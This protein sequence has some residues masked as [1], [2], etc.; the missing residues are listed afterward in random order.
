[1]LRV[2]AKLN[3][4]STDSTGSNFSTSRMSI[5]QFKPSPGKDLQGVSESGFLMYFRFWTSEVRVFILANYLL[6]WG[7]AHP[8]HACGH[9]CPLLIVPR[10]P[11]CLH[12]Q[13]VLFPLHHVHLSVLNVRNRDER[14][15][16]ESAL[17]KV[18]DKTGNHIY[19]RGPKAER[20]SSRISPWCSSHAL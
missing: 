19:F 4:W 11:G 8:I 13:E 17:S 2:S 9:L 14:L 6:A 3:D 10:T 5:C 7:F 12:L 1:M 20:R 18:D 16:K 15:S